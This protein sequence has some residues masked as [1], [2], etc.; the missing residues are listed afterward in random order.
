MKV[1]LSFLLALA[2]TLRAEPVGSATS[3]A[4]A[5][6]SVIGMSE[7]QVRAKYGPPVG[8]N[9]KPL[10]K[11]SDKVVMF[12]KGDIRIIVA[13]K[14]GRVWSVG[15]LR[16]KGRLEKDEML[17]LLRNHGGPWTEHYDARIKVT[18]WSCGANEMVARD[19]GASGLVINAQS[20]LIANRARVKSDLEGL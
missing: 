18:W 14:S 20:Y 19:E 6:G 13:F 3:A 4:V 7:P 8:E 16:N 17:Q 12:E 2:V 10:D 9:L 11:I 5:N 1:L 15:Y